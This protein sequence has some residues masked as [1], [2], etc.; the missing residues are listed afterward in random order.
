MIT[1]IEP[2]IYVSLEQYEHSIVRMT[3]K[4]MAL[5]QVAS[6]YQIG[7]V[8]VPGISDVDMVV[9]FKDD[10]TCSFNP[11]AQLSS[12]EKYLFVHSLFGLSET[13]FTSINDFLIQV[14]YI[15]RA[16]KKLIQHPFSLNA[17]EKNELNKQIALEYLVKNFITA[18]I[19]QKLKVVKLRN[20]LLEANALKYDFELLNIKE[21]KLYELVFE[22]ID[23][24]KKWFSSKPTEQT[25]KNWFNDYCHE[26]QKLL[27]QLFRTNILYSPLSSPVQLNK[28]VALIQSSSF[29]LKKSGITLPM[30]PGIK[31]LHIYKAANRLNRF[32]LLLPL[33]KPDAKSIHERRFLYLQQ[34]KNYNTKHAPFF[35]PMVSVL[36][37]IK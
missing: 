11:L 12:Q 32:K 28:N 15:H 2:P 16:G 14:Q 7:S 29:L 21:G 8:S 13:Q 36:P 9:V 37:F 23:W 1:L 19:Q 17:D 10:E 22:L 20:L 6:V 26:L 24:R 33:R 3:E 27:M 34:L 25:I 31:P 4:L 35:M 5:P 18:S 30:V